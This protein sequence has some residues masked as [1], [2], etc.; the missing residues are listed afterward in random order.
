MSDLGGVAVAIALDLPPEGVDLRAELAAHTRVRVNQALGRARDD[1]TAAAR[2]LRVSPLE[3]SRL[4]AGAQLVLAAPAA[5]PAPAPAPVAPTEFS[6]IEGG[7][8]ILSRAAIRRL[9]AQRFTARQI[10]DRFGVNEYFVE[11]I[12]RAEGELAKC[13]S[14]EGA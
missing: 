9:A 5:P 3:L 7:R 10:A 6:R 4:S 1:L 11:K 13:D 14:R 2:L 12:L 8:E